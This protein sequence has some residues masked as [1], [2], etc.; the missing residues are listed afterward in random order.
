MPTRL[1]LA[2][3]IPAA[4]VL[5]T[6]AAPVAAQDKEPPPLWDAS[7]GASF[8][9]TSGNSDTQTLGADASA[10][11]RWELWKVEALFT[12]V[13]TRDNGT[14]TA[15]RVLGSFRRRPAIARCRT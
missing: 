8:V 12:A 13:S 14:S 1:S 5:W 15:E 11:R 10:H 2:L 3:I 7:I 6:V 9:G 4:F